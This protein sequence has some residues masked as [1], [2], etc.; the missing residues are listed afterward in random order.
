MI[1]HEHLFYI[2][3]K[4]F[5]ECSLKYSVHASEEDLKGTIRYHENEHEQ[6]RKSLKTSKNFR[7]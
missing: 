4:Q 5:K 7:T 6:I 1:V 3:H 2:L